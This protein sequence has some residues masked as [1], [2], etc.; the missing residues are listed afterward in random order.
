MKICSF[1]KVATRQRGGQSLSNS[2][3]LEPL[4][5]KTVIGHRI[6]AS[7]VPETL[8]AFSRKSSLVS[9]LCWLDYTFRSRRI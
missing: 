3:V 7:C 4:E 1:G 9:A 5:S 2:S 6:A 8:A